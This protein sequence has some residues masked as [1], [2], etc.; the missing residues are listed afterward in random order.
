MSDVTAL[1]APSER[2][3]PLRRFE[4]AEHL[5]DLAG[6]ACLLGHPAATKLARLRVSQFHTART[7]AVLHKALERL[8]AFVAECA[9]RGHTLPA[10]HP[11]YVAPAALTGAR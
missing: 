7:D 2:L 3:S 1:A 9:A 6:A 11:C 10:S 5:I 8:S 4:L